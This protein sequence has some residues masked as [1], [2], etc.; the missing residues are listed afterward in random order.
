ML[1]RKIKQ[2]KETE[3]DQKGVSGKFFLRWGFKQR[4]ECTDQ[5]G[6]LMKRIPV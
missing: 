5:F 2:G 4:P 1:Q 3:R 6:D